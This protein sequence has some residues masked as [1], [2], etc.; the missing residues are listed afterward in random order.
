MSDSAQILQLILQRLSV[1][2]EALG[3]SGGPSSGG[4]GGSADLPRSIRAYDEYS[5]EKLDPFVDAC[6]KLGGDA[7]KAG[8][9][10]KETWDE[11]RAYLLLA[12]AC[13][14]PTQPELPGLLANVTAKMKAVG[15]AVQRNEW[16]K[17]LKTVS[18]GVSAVN[19]LCIKPAP[20]DFIEST[21][22]GSDYWANGIRKE[23]RTTNPDQVA[24]CDTFKALL[25]GLMDYVKEH[26]TTGVSW[27]PRGGKREVLFSIKLILYHPSFLTR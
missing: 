10:I 13:K 20:R 14:E 26:H 24:F 17:H 2:E 15:A 27:N 18:E 23:H 5:R 25:L 3:V 11:M 12:S 19:W 6:N 4:S 16:E 1:I 7:Q 21:V 22:G 9:L 8:Q